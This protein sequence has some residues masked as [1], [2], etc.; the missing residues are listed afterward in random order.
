MLDEK[1]FEDIE[2]RAARMG[3]KRTCLRVRT[4]ELTSRKD[5]TT[6]RVT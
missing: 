4:V 2:Q 3:S 5:I 6:V 1:V